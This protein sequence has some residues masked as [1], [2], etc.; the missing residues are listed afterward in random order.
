MKSNIRVKFGVK[1]RRRIN[2]HK[3]KQVH[4]HHQ[5]WNYAFIVKYLGNS[6]RIESSRGFCWEQIHKPGSFLLLPGKILAAS[7]N[8]CVEAWLPTGPHS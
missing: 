8:F 4:V 5:Y 3:K 1:F 7:L 2:L 6:D